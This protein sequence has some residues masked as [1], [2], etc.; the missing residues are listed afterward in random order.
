MDYRF[1][2]IPGDDND[3]AVSRKYKVI[4]T[5]DGDIITLE[6]APFSERTGEGIEKVGCE[7][8]SR[9]F[10]KE[11]VYNSGV[12]RKLKAR[13]IID[14]RNF[15]H[16]KNNNAQSHQKSVRAIVTLLSRRRSSCFIKLAP[17]SYSNNAL[18]FS[19]SPIKSI[20]RFR[21]SASS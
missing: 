14:R 15:Y 16:Q 12:R 8:Y 17:P 1:H 19:K 18:A 2:F 10:I 7:R 9:K 6:D 13:R 3:V 4:S 11:I 5:D 20:S 21:T